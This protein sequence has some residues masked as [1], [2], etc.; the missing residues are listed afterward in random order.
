MIHVYIDDEF[1]AVRMHGKYMQQVIA[2]G[3]W[4]CDDHFHRISSF[5]AFVRPAG[6]RCLSPHVRRM[7]HLRDEDIRS[8]QKFPAVADQFQQ[9]IKQQAQNEEVS[10]YSFGPDDGRT[11]SDNAAFYHHESEA[12]FKQVIDLQTLLSSRVTWQ[13]KVF[14]K[15]HSLE[16][17]K[18]IYQVKGEVNHNALSDAL[19]LYHIHQ[20]YREETALDQQYIE[21][22]YRSMHQR[23]IEGAIKRRKHQLQRCKERMEDKMGKVL[24]LSNTALTKWTPFYDAMIHLGTQLH[25]SALRSLRQQKSPLH[26][27]AYL[28]CNNQYVS[29]W[30]SF[31]YF[32][33]EVRYQILCSYHNVEALHQFLNQWFFAEVKPKA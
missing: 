15:T 9:W 32:D 3:A 33:H 26:V 4:M 16:S 10:I 30:F 17:L 13:G 25:F 11:L 12:V 31:I 22:L 18:H 7:T 2:I 20:A 19:D 6:F 5:Y 29:C 27:R 24:Y 14:Q 8:A 23:Q 21:E 1:D 28:L